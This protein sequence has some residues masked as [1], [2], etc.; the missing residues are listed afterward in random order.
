[1]EQARQINQHHTDT[2]AKQL[3]AARLQAGLSLRELAA[4]ANTSHATLLAY[5]QGKK[6]PAI[7]TFLRILEAAGFA[8]DIQLSKRIR[9]KDGIPRGEELA[10]VLKLAEQFPAKINKKM[11]FPVWPAKRQ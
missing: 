10:A 5:E 9:E 6:A 11:N 3:Q 7:T 4:R 1:M 8:V 2:A